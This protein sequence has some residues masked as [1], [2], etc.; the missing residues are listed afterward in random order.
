MGITVLTKENAKYAAVVR[1]I[2]HP[3]WGTFRFRYQAEPLND[4]K[5]LDIIGS[6][7]DSRILFDD[8]Y[9]LWEVV[10]FKEDGVNN[11]H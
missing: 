4:G 3:E 7:C 11:G 5:Y 10:K 9:H 1:S 6:G 8:E 2:D